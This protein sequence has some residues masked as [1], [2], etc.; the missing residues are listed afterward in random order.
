MEALPS[1]DTFNLSMVVYIP[2]PAAPTTAI[3]SPD[4]DDD[5]DHDENNDDSDDDDVY[6]N[7]LRPVKKAQVQKYIDNNK[8]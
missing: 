7:K 5:D 6:L 3:I 8:T 4:D 1:S 2:Y